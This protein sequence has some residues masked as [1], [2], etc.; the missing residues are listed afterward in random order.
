M[1]KFLLRRFSLVLL[2]LIALILVI[3][4]YRNNIIIDKI[5]LK[6]VDIVSPVISLSNSAVNYAFNINNNIQHL[7][8]THADNQILRM[9][10]EELKVFYHLYLQ[11]KEEN[12]ELKKLL[13]FISESKLSYVTARVIGESN[14]PYIRSV[15]INAGS[16]D[17]V[18]AKQAVI[19]YYGLVGRVI[20]VGEKTSRVLLLTDINSK[21]PVLTAETRER[22]ILVGNNS[23]NL[24]VQY[25]PDDSRTKV[26]E[27]VVTSG[28]AG[29]FP[30]GLPVG[31]ITKIEE[32]E[33]F[34]KPFIEWNRLDIINVIDY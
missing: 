3:I 2:V 4:D 28:D 15:L 21:I 10:N 24:T 1:I 29:I 11:L 6:I 18:K 23:T 19:N 27:L 33:V 20:E 34:I 13:N 30:P 31:T 8:K 7:F 26:G 9:E 25:L 12:N 14:T 32:N 5:K 17:K 22:G 16:I